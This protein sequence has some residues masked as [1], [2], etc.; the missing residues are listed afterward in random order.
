VAL[1]LGDLANPPLPDESLAA[2]WQAYLRLWSDGRRHDALAS[3]RSLV[4]EIE[5]A[6]PQVCAA[7]ARW[8]CEVLF[9]R[10]EHWAGQWGGGLSLREG[11]WEKP[12]EFAL[13][14]HPITL[15]LILPYLL[16]KVAV[17]QD[18]H[19]RWAYQFTV[20]QGCRLPPPAQRRLFSAIE[21]R[22]GPGAAPIDLL[23]HAVD[24]P[25][26]RRMLGDADADA[27]H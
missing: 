8:W 2:G 5:G 18:R 21:S 12:V 6:G 25:D 27:E 1:T 23:E 22:C 4:D 26:A 14:V 17:E 9:D 24:D 20:G 15:R 3:V 11:R 16:G 13:T 10:S 7:F 19:L